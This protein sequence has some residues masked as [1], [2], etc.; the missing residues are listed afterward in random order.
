MWMVAKCQESSSH[1]H[2]IQTYIDGDEMRCFR[3][4]IIIFF[5]SFLFSFIELIRLLDNDW[6]W[7]IKKSA[8]NLQP[9][10]IVYIMH[11]IFYTDTTHKIVVN[12]ISSISVKSS[13]H[14]LYNVFNASTEYWMQNM[15]IA[16]DNVKVH[17]QPT[18]VF[19]SYNIEYKAHKN[20]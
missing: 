19:G 11:F 12:R 1:F 2:Y 14:H 17:K 10:V 3:M 4:L 6:I 18:T 20:S 8:L 16:L 7:W 5:L 13:W 15:E 9:N